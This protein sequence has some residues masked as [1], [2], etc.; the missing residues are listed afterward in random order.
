MTPPRIKAGRSTGAV[1]SLSIG[2]DQNDVLRIAIAVVAV[3][4]I[5]GSIWNSKRNEVSLGDDVATAEAT[6]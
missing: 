3:A 6:A 5:V 4:I 1:V 2:E